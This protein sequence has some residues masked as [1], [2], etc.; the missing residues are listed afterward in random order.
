MKTPAGPEDPLKPRHQLYIDALRGWAIL[1][2]MAFHAAACVPGW[3]GPLCRL[4][5]SGGYGVQLFFVV[6]AITLFQSHSSR[7]ERD[8]KPY[9]AFFVR[10]IFR[11]LPMFWV[12]IAFYLFWYGAGPR[13]FSPDG[14]TTA[15]VAATAVCAHGW[16]PEQINSV[17]PGGW[18][19]AVEMNFYLL[20]PLMFLLAT[21]LSRA[22]I[23]FSIA[24]GI[25]IA[26]EFAGIPDRLFPGSALVKDLQFFWLPVQLPV[27]V[28]GI[29]AY[30]MTRSQAR[31]VE[32]GL[33]CLAIALTILLV[34][35]VG[36]N[37]FYA[38]VFVL[39]VTILSRYPHPLAVN[40]LT[41]FLGKISFSA[42]LIHFAVLDLIRVVV[43]AQNVEYHGS[44]PQWLPVSN[45]LGLVDATNWPRTIHFG[46]VMVAL[47]AGTTILSTLT[48]Y[49]IEQPGIDVGKKLLQRLGWSD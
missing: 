42:Y 3:S 47:T 8:R 17:V 26:L 29:M 48:H 23:L 38:A 37:V 12:G 45:W 28:L 11:I 46:V 14:I 15:D 33:A 36:T 39:L 35:F 22:T 41:R 34:S 27:F 10:R 6:S 9:L 40:F 24:L 20:F 32:R 25:K 43:H 31:K 44:V 5:V 2:V 30:H 49:L 18:S 21:T 16:R 1:G 7:L 13:F 19:I 4:M